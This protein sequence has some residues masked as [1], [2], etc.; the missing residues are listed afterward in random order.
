[1]RWLQVVGSFTLY[2]SFAE[3]RLF[4][5]AP[6]QKRPVIL[7]SILSVDTPYQQTSCSTSLEDS[8]LLPQP[9]WARSLVP[10]ASV[11]AAVYICY[12]CTHTYSPYIYAFIYIRI[13]ICM[14][15]YMY[16]Y[17]NIC[18]YTYSYMYTYCEIS[19]CCGCNNELVYR[20]WAEEKRGRACVSPAEINPFLVFEQKQ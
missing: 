3:Y 10:K 20:G 11:V 14:Y 8:G 1:M 19:S 7:R 2:V 15:M 12:T 18:M 16:I 9:Q 13:Y 5:R 6:L 17:I 4:Y